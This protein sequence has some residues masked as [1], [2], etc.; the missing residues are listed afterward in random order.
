MS[1]PL[2]LSR[3]KIWREKLFLG[4]VQIEINLCA[5]LSFCTKPR[6]S[7]SRQI[8]SREGGGTNQVES[9]ISTWNPYKKRFPYRTCFSR[10]DLALPFLRTAAISG[11]R[12]RRPLIGQRF[13]VPHYSQPTPNQWPKNLR[14][15]DLPTQILPASGSGQNLEAKTRIF[16]ILA[17]E[18][19]HNLRIL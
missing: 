14:S 19:F 1:I 17:G 5:L 13:V 6:Q 7:S 12:R 2:G 15:Q 10:F 11:P 16:L 4:L 18:T 3:D 9:T 8:F